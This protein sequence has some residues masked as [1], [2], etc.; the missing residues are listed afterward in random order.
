MDWKNEIIGLP[1]NVIILEDSSTDFE[2]ISEQLRSAG[3]AL[4]INH[5]YNRD[6]FISLLS[7]GNCCDIILSDFNLPGFD[8]FEALEISKKLRPDTPFIC[9]SGSI[10]EEIAIEILKNGAVDYVLKD[11]P[12]RLPFAVKRALDEQKEK[13]ALKLAEEELKRNEAKF[14]TLTENIP[15]IIVR[16]DKNLRHIYINPAIE[17]IT[18]I[19][20]EHFIG[21]TNEDLNMPMELVSIWNEKMNYVFQTG[22]QRIYEFDFETNDST[23]SFLSMLVPEFSEDGAV[24]TL[25]CVTRDITDRKRIENDLRKSEERLRDIIFSSAD[26][27]W[28]VDKEGRY[29]F[30]SQKVKE[31]LV[32]SEKEILGKTPFDFMPE[33]EAKRVSEIFAGVVTKREAIVDLEN[34]NIGKN[35]E[36]I[37]LLTNG[38]PILNEVGELIGYRGI[39]KNITERKLS[40]QELIKAKERAEESDR[41]KS[42]FLANMSHEIRTPMNGILGFAGLLKNSDLS[43]EQQQEYIRIIEKSGERM[44]N[45]INDIVSISKIESGIVDVRLSDTNINSQMQHVYDSLV[46]DADSKGI[47]LSCV[48]EAADNEVI[49]RT[50]S[51][52]INGILTNLVKN[53]IKYTFAGKV[54]YGYTA[55]DDLIEFY[56]KDTGIGIPKERQDAI[57]ERFIQADIVDKMARQGAGL[58]LAI[59][60]A[61]VE[62]LGGK[63]W[64]ESEEGV[65]SLFSFTLPRN[66]VH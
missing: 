46:F 47:N 12:N 31:L 50:D 13:S 34:W 33:E 20:K 39:D 54:E 18:G 24:H 15:D 63:I 42:A 32:A 64:V 8:A 21:K 53:A 41:L 62:M 16:F 56:V 25:L 43:G 58:G 61:Y 6:E 28:E 27:V 35:G 3:F 52:K 59:S 4:N 26:W 22:E 38:R 49:V 51:E 36:L 7:N 5:A 45:I 57:F 17:K 66:Q 9:I 19:R 10:G 29:T 60:K 55:K 1:L 14:R 37:C 65:G 23:H 40:E 44:L 11:R 30:S 48:C 2:L